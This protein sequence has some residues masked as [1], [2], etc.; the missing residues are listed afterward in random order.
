MEKPVAIQQARSKSP[1]YKRVRL[2]L[3][4]RYRD[5][6]Q[7]YMKDEDAQC[8]KKRGKTLHVIEE[9]NKSTPQIRRHV[10]TLGHSSPWTSYTSCKLNIA[11]HDGDPLRMNGT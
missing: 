7:K 3:R 8:N 2:L 4:S 6:S 9:E 10:K 1:W 11:L 5:V